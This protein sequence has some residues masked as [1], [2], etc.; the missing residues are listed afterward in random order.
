MG[1]PLIDLHI[2][3]THFIVVAGGKP[4][5]VFSTGIIDRGAVTY[6]STE[7]LY[8]EEGPKISATSGCLSQASRP[9]TH[10]YEIYLEKATIHYEAGSPLKVYTE[11]GLETP[12]LAGGDE[13]DS[14]KDEI[15]AAIEAIKTN[16]P[17][18]LLDG[19]L[20]RDALAL[21]IHEGESVAT[22][23]AIDVI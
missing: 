16:K 7:Y 14:F 10:G 4:K 15:T 6:V 11:V 20:A 1:G 23:K 2:H 21:C 8:D 9:F 13:I 18:P 19:Q 5:K 17:S 22:G 3:D 12:A